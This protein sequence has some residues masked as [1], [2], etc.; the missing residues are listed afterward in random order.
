MRHDRTFVEKMALLSL[1][2]I[3]IASLTILGVL[4]LKAGGV[5]ANTATL[6]GVIVGGLIAVGK[7]V[8]QA[9]RGYA[10]A[11]QL[12]KVTDQLAASGPVPT[13][14]PAP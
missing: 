3:A 11:A 5:D 13:D 4:A 1:A 12:S 10:M 14:E 9:I 8:V 2:A 7:D 6:E